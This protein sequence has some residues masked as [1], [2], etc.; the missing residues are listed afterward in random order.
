MSGAGA[1]ARHP[2][3]IGRRTRVKPE[4]IAGY[5]DWHQ[6][7]WPEIVALTRQAGIRNYTIYMDGP[8]LF[9]YF[10]VDDLDAAMAFLSTSEVSDRWQALMA[11][12]MDAPSAENPW[13]VLEEVFHQ[14]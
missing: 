14:D 13:R 8:E 10:E 11:P 9:S 5:R 7:V 3:R 2:H 1:A 4:A 12:L 6:R